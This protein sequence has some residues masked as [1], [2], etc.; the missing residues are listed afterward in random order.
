MVKNNNL[1]FE[2]VDGLW[3]CFLIDQNHSLAE[4]VPLQLLLLD[5]GLDSE[6]DGLTGVSL[7]DIHAF[8]MDA[9]HLHWI[10]L[11]L[12]VRSEQ[13]CGTRDNSAG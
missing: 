2:I 9:L 11:A 10:E 13:E 5:L 4:V 12:L 6:T 3:L 8:V 1:S 7:F